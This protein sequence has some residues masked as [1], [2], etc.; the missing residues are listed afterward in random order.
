MQMKHRHGMTATRGFTLMELMITIAVAAI[1]ASIAVPSFATMQQN[2]A[3]RTALNN[4]WHA[5]FLARS[6]AIKRNSVIAIC[7]SSDGKNCSN[8]TDD[9]SD[10]WIVFD[11][12]D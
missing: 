12:L 1:L 7:K 10:G 4:F 3:R 11:N 8:S 9:W 5:I 2:A 6:E